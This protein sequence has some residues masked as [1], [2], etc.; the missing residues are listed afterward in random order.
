MEERCEKCEQA[1]IEIHVPWTSETLV[2]GRLVKLTG[3]RVLSCPCGLSP[4]I[5]ALGPLVDQI[6]EIPYPRQMWNWNTSAQAW[7][8]RGSW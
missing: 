2:K 1:L 8:L 4:E 7:D 3:I 6:Q 5:P